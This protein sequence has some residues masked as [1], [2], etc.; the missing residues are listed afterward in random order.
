MSALQFV[1]NCIENL[2]QRAKINSKHRS[3]EEIVF[4]VPEGAILGPLLFII[5]LCDLF[6]IVEAFHINIASYADD[7]TPYTTGNSIEEVIQKL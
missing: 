4:A 3:R 7:S 2:T 1:H 6:F 5:F